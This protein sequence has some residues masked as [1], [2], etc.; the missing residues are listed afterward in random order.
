[1]S[2]CSAPRTWGWRCNSPTSPAT[3]VRT[4]AADACISPPPCSTRS[5]PIRAA[6]PRGL[7]A[8]VRAPRCAACSSR[9]TR[10]IAP[11]IS[12]CRSCLAG[13]VWRSRRAGGSTRPSVRPCAKMATTRSPP[14]PTSRSA[15]KLLLVLGASTAAL[16]PSTPIR[17]L[18]SVGTGRRGAGR[19]DPRVRPCAGSRAGMSLAD[20]LRREFPRT[21]AAF[22][23]LEDGEGALAHVVDL[24][25]RWNRPGLIE[26]RTDGPDGGQPDFDVLLAGGGLS[27]FYG[28]Y[29]ARRGLR[30]AIF[31]RG[32]IGVG[33]REWNTSRT[34]L[35]PLVE[36][37]LFTE[38]ETDALIEV[39]YREG[40]CRWHGGG[41]YPVRHV[42][43]CVVAAAPLLKGLRERAEQA[44]ATLLPRHA[45]L[46]YTRGP[47]G[48]EVRLASG[49]GEQRL[50][51]RML[52]DG[53]GAASPHARL[54]PVS[55][56]R[57]A[58]C[59]ADLPIRERRRTRSTPRSARSSSPPRTSKRAASTSGRA[60][61]GTEAGASPPTSSTTTSRAA[62]RS[63]RC[64]RSTS[65]SSPPCRATSA[66]SRASG[67]A[68][69]RL[70]PAVH[71]APSHAGGAARSRAPRRR[72]GRAPLA[73]D[74]LRLRLDAALVPA[75]GRSASSAAWAN[76][77]LGRRA[78]A[79]GWR[80]HR[81]CR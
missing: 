19:R 66:A 29:L 34:E 80:S 26:I 11:P 3:W 13:V 81:P 30:V 10:I 42:L 44:G 35:R 31:D 40:I 56:R 63:G 2:R 37:G 32:E 17:S 21:A 68:D 7:P 72:R 52:L 57:W 64:C 28:A 24:E 60:F 1:M 61:P 51:G 39:E 65:A 22:A 15:R 33:H 6:S 47:G 12:A 54:R 18:A 58:A 62:C 73:A 74:L 70:H 38:E 46:G 67:E 9:R 23:Q 69:L 49:E 71:P 76:D 25:S 53:M 77:R 45:M 75:G 48:V 27:L 16:G 8:T 4:R 36:S 55:A 20:E 14:A 59:C 43:D 41:T 78:L 5:G 50:S 79:V